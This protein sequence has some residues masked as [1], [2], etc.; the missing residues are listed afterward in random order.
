VATCNDEVA[1]DGPGAARTDV[2]TSGRE[3]RRRFLRPVRPVWLLVIAQAA[4]LTVL[5]TVL[6]TVLATG[7]PHHGAGAGLSRAGP[8]APIGPA[9]PQLSA[10]VLRLPAGGGVAGTVVITAAALPGAGRAQFTVSGVVTGGAP[11]T[12]YDL[13]GSDCSTADPPP[14]D[15]WATGLAGADG[16]AD[17]AGYTWTGAVAD[18]YWLSLDPSPA[19]APPGLHGRFG[20]GQ[21]TPFPAG[22]APC[23]TAS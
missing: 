10:V 17:L 7:T 16:T 22:Q 6:I 1:A 11:G 12:F 3:P 9:L 5:A 4:A 20:Q 2:I 19:G 15:V 13:I 18:S 21:A 14:D 8:P 23:A